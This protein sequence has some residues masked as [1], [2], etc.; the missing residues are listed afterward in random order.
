MVFLEALSQRAWKLDGAIEGLQ[1]DEVN[2]DIPEAG[3][4]EDV[5]MGWFMVHVVYFHLYSRALELEYRHSVAAY[6]LSSCGA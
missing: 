3:D 4:S 1:G 5:A 2:A 6:D